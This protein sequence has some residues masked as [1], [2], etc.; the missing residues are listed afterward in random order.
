MSLA[1]SSGL[2]KI[3]VQADQACQGVY[4]E[5]IYVDERVEL[6]P[7]PF[8]GTLNIKIENQENKELNIKVLNGSGTI[9]YQAKQR[10]NNHLISLDLSHLES[11]Y[12]FVVIGK[13]TYKVIKK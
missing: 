1:L 12:Y 9:V 6:Y 11:G 8:T 2:N 13:Q 5:E 10:V 3:T 4:T 7:N